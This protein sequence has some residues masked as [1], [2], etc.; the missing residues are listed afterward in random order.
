MPKYEKTLFGDLNSF[1]EHLDSAILSGSMTASLEDSSY[2]TIG[3]AAVAVRVYERFSAW[4]QNRVSLNV[5]VV[6]WGSQLYV[7]AI[8]SGGTDALFWKF[9]PIGEETFLDKAVDAIEAFNATPGM[10]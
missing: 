6:G 3:Q 4:G 2:T 10:R 8:T 9:M 1:V 7:S 5:T